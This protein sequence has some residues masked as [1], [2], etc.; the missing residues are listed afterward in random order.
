[1]EWLAECLECPLAEC[2][3]CLE[4]PLAEC[5]ECLE[6]PLV[7]WLAECLASLWPPAGCKV[8]CPERD[9]CR[10]ARRLLTRW[11]LRQG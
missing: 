11:A 9:R 7:E 4:C 2:L 6:C 5:L 10:K 8:D 3:E 1:V